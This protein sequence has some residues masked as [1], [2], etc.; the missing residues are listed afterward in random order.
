MQDEA[1]P[2]PIPTAGVPGWVWGCGAGCAVLLLIGILTA[3]GSYRILMGIMEE[4]SGDVLVR[5]EDQYSEWS[6]TACIPDEQAVLAEELV[7]VARS[8]ETGMLGKTIVLISLEFALKDC[9]VSPEELVVLEDARS[10]LK[11]NPAPSPIAM[12]LFMDR[13]SDAFERKFE[14]DAA[15]SPQDATKAQPV[16]EAS[17]EPPATVP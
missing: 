8:P 16:E 15:Q 10:T 5:L 6:A 4:R 14:Q 9:V 11:D 13:H 1:V 2:P 12:A 3:V 7:G 17:E